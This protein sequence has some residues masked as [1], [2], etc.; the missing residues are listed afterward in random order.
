[1]AIAL[2]NS[3]VGTQEVEVTFSFDI[4]HFDALGVVDDDLCL[5]VAMT[6]V[7]VFEFEVIVGI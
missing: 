1:M 5:G 7:F 4:E 3:T 6:G 2:V